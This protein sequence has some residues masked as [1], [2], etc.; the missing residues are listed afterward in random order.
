MSHAGLKQRES[1]TATL[2]VCWICSAVSNAP[3]LFSPK[4]RF[5]LN[6]RRAERLEVGKARG[7][8]WRAGGHRRRRIGR[9]SRMVMLERTVAVTGPASRDVRAAS[10]AESLSRE[11][12]GRGGRLLRLSQ[13][14][15]R[16]RRRCV[17]GSGCSGSRWRRSV[18]RNRSRIRIDSGRIQTARHHRRVTL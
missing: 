7:G 13:M 10:V 4:S 11:E 18:M 1:L 6:E 8:R 2:L 3:L 14:A 12:L 9:P 15:E 16:G 17:I 5:G